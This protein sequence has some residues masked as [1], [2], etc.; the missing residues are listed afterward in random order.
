MYESASM[1]H[2]ISTW[3]AKRFASV[4]PTQSAKQSKSVTDDSTTLQ[5]SGVEVSGIPSREGV[6]WKCSNC[7][8]D[9]CEHVQRAAAWTAI[10]DGGES[11]TECPAGESP[12]RDDSGVEAT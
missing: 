2:V 5:I 4:R 7:G 12:R 1:P 10:I 9:E 6:R 11:N 8:G 3:I